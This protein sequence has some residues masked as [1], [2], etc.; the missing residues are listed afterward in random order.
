MQIQSRGA[1]VETPQTDGEPK[2]WP[3][4]L[5]G[6]N[7]DPLTAILDGSKGER[8][9][10]TACTLASSASLS[11]AFDIGESSE[12]AGVSGSEPPDTLSSII[13]ASNR[14]H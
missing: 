14:E 9:S 4:G 10:D 3:S 1:G 13:P 7:F 12:V 5:K 6:L 8:H 11:L 2:G